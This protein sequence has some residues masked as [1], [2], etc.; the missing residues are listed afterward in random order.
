M[1]SYFIYPFL[2]AHFIFFLRLISRL[3]VLNVC[4]QQSFLQHQGPVFSQSVCA[5]PYSFSTKILFWNGCF[6][7]R[8]KNFLHKFLFLYPSLKSMVKRLS[9][10]F[11]KPENVLNFFIFHLDSAVSSLLLNILLKYPGINKYLQ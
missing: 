1:L 6:L 5:R 9:H 8:S 10:M 4:L 2:L 11:Y 3:K 7:T